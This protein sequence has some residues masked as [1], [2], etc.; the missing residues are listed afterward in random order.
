[1]KLPPGQCDREQM[2]PKQAS[3]SPSADPRVTPDKG[4]E[5]SRQRV[6]HKTSLATARWE[7]V[8]THPAPPPGR[9]VPRAE[10]EQA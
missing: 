3:A 7:I 6:G 4:R 10:V 8:R 1:M 5:L 9:C 2:R